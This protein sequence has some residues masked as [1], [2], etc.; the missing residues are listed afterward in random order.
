MKLAIIGSRTI[1]KLSLEGY[2]PPETTLIISGGK[3]R[4]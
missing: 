4:G 3:R 1:E 2:I